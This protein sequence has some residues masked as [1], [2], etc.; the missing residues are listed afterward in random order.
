MRYHHSTV[1]HRGPRKERINVSFRLLHDHTHNTHTS[2]FSYCIMIFWKFCFA[3]STTQKKCSE[4][5]IDSY[6]ILQFFPKQEKITAIKIP[7]H[8]SR[9][10]YSYTCT[11]YGVTK[12]NRDLVMFRKINH[13][14]LKIRISHSS[15]S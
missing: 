13:G 2:A 14:R 8:V 3:I 5:I 6:K 7:T 12:N 9:L 15:N 10:R 1:G 11:F 4:L